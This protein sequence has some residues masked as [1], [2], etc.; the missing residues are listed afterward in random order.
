MLLDND[1]L[2]ELGFLMGPRKQ[3]LQWIRAH[4]LS[5]TVSASPNS[6]IPSSPSTPT[7]SISTI[8]PRQCV[9]QVQVNVVICLIG[10][11]QLLG[12]ILFF[13][14]SQFNRNFLRFF[15]IDC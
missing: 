2:K 6:N 5:P 8:G 12:A 14:Y 13:W 10:V 11:S 1:D 4:H 9:R 7:T 15:L 3:L